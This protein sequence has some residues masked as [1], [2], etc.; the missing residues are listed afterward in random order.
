[1]PQN[2]YHSTKP[3]QIHFTNVHG[4]KKDGSLRVFQDFRELNA[5]SHDDRYSSK[6]AK[7]CKFKNV[8]KWVSF[9]QANPD[10]LHQCSR[11][12]KRMVL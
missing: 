12:Q 2:G 6:T 11:Y 1:M 8:S 10:T 7:K 9:N 5:A 3:I 4:T